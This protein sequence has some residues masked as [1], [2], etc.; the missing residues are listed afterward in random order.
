MKTILILLIVAILSGATTDNSRVISNRP[1]H[2]IKAGATLGFDMQ[3]QP[4][5]NLCWAAVASSISKFYN[6]K[7]GYEQCDIASHVLGTDGCCA[8]MDKC[9]KQ[10]ALDDA[11]T[12]TKNLKGSVQ[13]GMPSFDIIKNEITNGYVIAL[14]VQW[15]NKGGHFIVIYGFHDGDKVDVKDPWPD[16]PAPA[17]P[18]SLIELEEFYQNNGKITHYYLTKKEFE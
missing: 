9:N 7:L 15:R 16:Y 10:A 17:N 11:L 2:N 8:D 1:T 6:Q 18:L 12:Y 4:R 5:F 3:I 13:K 14:R